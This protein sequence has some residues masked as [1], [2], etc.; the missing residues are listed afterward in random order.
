MP[1]QLKRQRSP[2]T[3]R[4]RA[5]TVAIDAYGARELTRRRAYLRSSYNPLPREPL[6]PDRINPLPS[7]PLGA[8]RVLN[9]TRS[10]ITA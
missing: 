10:H 4:C 7:R 8:T 1:D 5:R 2:L 9:F 3:S 6:R